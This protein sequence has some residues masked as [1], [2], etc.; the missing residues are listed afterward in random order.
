[1]SRKLN[2]ERIVKMGMRVMKKINI[3]LYWSKYS[4]KDYTIRQHIMLIVLVQCVGNVERLL[5]I[6]RAMD[7]ARKRMRLKKIP[8]K[9]TISRVSREIKGYQSY[10]FAL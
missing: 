8:H 9:S 4:R 5:Q 3:P 10:G 2:L 7:K 6:L 1:M